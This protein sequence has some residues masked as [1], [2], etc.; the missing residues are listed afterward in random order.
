LP[1]LFDTS[2]HRK[3]GAKYRKKEGFY[4]KLLNLQTKTLQKQTHPLAT[5]TAILIQ[6]SAWLILI[7]SLYFSTIRSWQEGYE[8]GF[9]HFSCGIFSYLVAF[10]GNALWLFP[11]LIKRSVL[12]VIATILFVFLV[13]IMR[14]YFEYVLILPINKTF[15]SFS[16]PHL[17]H[18]TITVLVAYVVGGLLRIAMDY[19]I[20][21]KNQEELKRQQAI[22]ELNL[23]KAQVQPHFLFNTLNNIYSL[24]VAKSEKTPE[25]IA[26]LSE[27]MRYFV[28]EAPKEKVSIET[29]INF[30]KNYIELEQI[31]MLFPLKL[32]FQNTVNDTKK[33]IPPMLFIPLVENIFKHG[34]DKVKQDNF[35]AISLNEIE[36]T[37]FFTVKNKMVESKEKIGFGLINLQKRLDLLYPE[38]YKLTSQIIDN[39]FVVNLKIPVL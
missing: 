33:M 23:L 34:I 26:R 30:L 17:S 10:Y 35:A 5:P 13:M 9:I 4:G 14:S 21:Q 24:A 6:L 37:Y 25:T 29:E 18:N 16:F 39:Q 1:I 8:I 28:D 27:I 11:R 12:Y 36:N 22:S 32:D 7:L 3:I 20:L 38:N 15:R 19:I 2:N 31:R